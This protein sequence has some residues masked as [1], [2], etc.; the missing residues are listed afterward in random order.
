MD[1]E[2][3]NLHEI[4]DSR[5]GTVSANDYAAEALRLMTTHNLSWSFVIDRNQVAGIVQAQDLARLSDALL[6]ECDVREYVI[7]NLLTVSIETELQEAIRLLR[8]SGHHFLGVIKNN[9]PV[10]ILT[11]ES[12]PEFNKPNLLAC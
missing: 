6:K 3:M 7:T 2:I 8:R 1:W 5:I 11:Q 9:L 10:G 12:L 4:M